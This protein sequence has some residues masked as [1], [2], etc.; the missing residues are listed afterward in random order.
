MECRVHGVVVSRVP[1]AEPVIRFTRD[2]EME[3]TWLMTVANRKTVSGFLHV[4]W[5]TA[6][7]IAGRV[8]GR[9][10]SGMPCMFDGLT[11]IGCLCSMVLRP[12]ERLVFSP[13]ER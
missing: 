3:C 10:E 12:V 13:K 1:W 5:R 11:A 9:L 2:F 4:A 6:G 8:A 7:D